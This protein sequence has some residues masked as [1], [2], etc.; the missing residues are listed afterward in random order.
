MGVFKRSFIHI[1]Q[2][3][4]IIFFRIPITLVIINFYT[5]DLTTL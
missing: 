4:D 5:F 3:K 1:L 2:H